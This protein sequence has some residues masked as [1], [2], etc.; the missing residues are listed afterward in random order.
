MDL[1]CPMPFDEQNKWTLKYYRSNSFTDW[2]LF[3]SFIKKKNFFSF[4]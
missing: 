2:L 3:Q 4:L 1:L